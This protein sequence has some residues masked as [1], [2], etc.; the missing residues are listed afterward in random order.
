M[1]DLDEEIIEF[2]E[3]VEIIKNGIAKFIDLQENFPKEKLTPREL[4]K[5]Y[6]CIY[7]LCAIHS[8]SPQFYDLY[9]Q[10][11]KEYIKGI[12]LSSLREKQDVCFL[13]ELVKR[14]KNYKVMCSW[15]SSHL[16]QYLDR[17]YTSDERWLP[18]LAKVGFTYFYDAVSQD[19]NMKARDIV[20]SLIEKEREGTQIDRVLLKNVTDYFVE[21]GAGWDNYFFKHGPGFYYE[22]HYE[23]GI[24]SNTASYYLGKAMSWISEEDNGDQYYIERAKECLKREEENVSHYLTYVSKDKLLATVQ[25]Q[26]LSV[27]EKHQLDKAKVEELS[28]NLSFS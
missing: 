5:L 15:M 7:D 28:R 1:T 17:Y 16:F 26:L 18:S 20:I 4:M 13:S 27:Y 8:Y 9:E 21:V 24:L 11:I 14:W 2:E 22:K 10:T 3:G 12:V 23:E 6:S 25:Q 19:I